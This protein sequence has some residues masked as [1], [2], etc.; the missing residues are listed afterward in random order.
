MSETVQNLND[1]KA[2]SYINLSFLY[3]G[4]LNAAKL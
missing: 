2:F 4:I 3:F 1:C